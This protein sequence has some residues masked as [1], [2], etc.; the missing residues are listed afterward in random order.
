[1]LVLHHLTIAFAFFTLYSVED[2][3]ASDAA[4]G[5]VLGADVLR[6]LEQLRQKLLPFLQHAVPEKKEVT[7]ASAVPSPPP[8]APPSAPLRPGESPFPAPQGLPPVS[9]GDILPPGLGGGDPG[10]L[11]GPDSALFGRRVDPSRGPVPGARFDPFGP[12]ID[13]LQMPGRGGRGGFRPGPN[14]PFGTPNPD[15]LRMPREDDDMDFGFGRQPPPGRGG[16]FGDS[17][18]PFGSDHSFF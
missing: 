16:G 12:P 8:P 10:M 14:L 3:I 4:T 6:N 1:M 11:V 17:S 13:P 18:R 5:P 9:S 2:Y 15:H 7:R